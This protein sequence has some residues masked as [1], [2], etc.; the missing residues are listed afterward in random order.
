MIFRIFITILILS[1]IFYT[2]SILRTIN[3]EVKQ[4]LSDIMEYQFK[5]KN[6]IEFSRNLWSKSDDFI[7]DTLVDTYMRV[8]FISVET[9]AYKIDPFFTKKLMEEREAE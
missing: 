4:E 2:T 3:T 8:N 5:I 7:R 9:G 6:D 1:N